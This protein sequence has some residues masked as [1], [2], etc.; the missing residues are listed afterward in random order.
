MARARAQ[1]RKRESN[2]SVA[3]TVATRVPVLPPMHQE[4]TQSPCAVAHATRPTHG[5]CAEPMHSRPATRTARASSLSKSWYS[6]ASFRTWFSTPRS[7]FSRS[8]L[9]SS[10]RGAAWRGAGGG[11]RGRGC[12]GNWC[13]GQVAGCVAAWAAGWARLR[14]C[15]LPGRAQQPWA[16]LELGWHHPG[17][18]WR[19]KEGGSVA[20]QATCG[21]GAAQHWPRCAGSP[22]ALALR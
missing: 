18:D 17:G 7:R 3:A 21:A 1:C 10:L 9:N 22:A 2:K 13:Q 5:P 19:S 8:W 15:S 12:Q 11:G 16:A 14:S 20:G 4:P 6:A